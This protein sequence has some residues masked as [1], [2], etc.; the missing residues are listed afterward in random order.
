M[1]RLVHST[2]QLQLLRLQIKGL[3]LAP[4]LW[5]EHKAEARDEI[6]LGYINKGRKLHCS[7]WLREATSHVGVS[8]VSGSSCGHLHLHNLSSYKRC[9]SY[10]WHVGGRRREEGAGDCWPRQ[11][12]VSLWPDATFGISMVRLTITVNYKMAPR[13]SWLVHSIC[14]SRSQARC[15]LPEWKLPRGNPWQSLWAGRGRE[16][17][18]GG[19]G[20]E[21]WGWERYSRH[22]IYNHSAWERTTFRGNRVKEQTQSKCPQVEI[23]YGLDRSMTLRK[24]FAFETSP[25]LKPI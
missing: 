3:P 18:A 19:G 21:N 2:K 24:L 10:V 15:A 11:P 16:K 12:S 14:E 8:S 13:D 4:L 1:L 25:Y 22:F 7:L 5:T 9:S 23:K 6:Q 17:L 20:G